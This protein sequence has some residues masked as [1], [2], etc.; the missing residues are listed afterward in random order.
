MSIERPGS[1]CKERALR[2]ASHDRFDVESA[3]EG[4]LKRDFRFAQIAVIPTT[5]WRLGQ[6][7]PQAVV[8][9]A[10]RVDG[11]GIDPV[12]APVI[13]TFLGF[14]AMSA[15]ALPHLDAAERS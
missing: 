4:R 1:S 12:T 7:D 8:P 6:I 9:R 15:P 3:A 11:V 2:C 5:A 14:V 10:Q 13:A